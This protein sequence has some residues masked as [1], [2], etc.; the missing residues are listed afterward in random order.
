M[1]KILITG[2]GGYIGSVATYL[3]LKKGYEV[4]ALDNFSTGFKG[5][6]D[7][8]KENINRITI[9]ISANNLASPAIPKNAPARNGLFFTE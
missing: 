6:L 2:A 8:M 4:V 9:G 3:L 5:P 7:L 1:Q